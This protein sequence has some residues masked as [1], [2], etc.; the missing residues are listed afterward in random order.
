MASG[1]LRHDTDAMGSRRMQEGQVEP[2]LSRGGLRDGLR[3]AAPHLAQGCT[4]M[5]RV[6]QT[7]DVL[8]G[9]VDRLGEGQGQLLTESG[10]LREYRETPARGNPNRRA[11]Q[12]DPAAAAHTRQVC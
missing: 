9:P 10:D 6:P 12:I 7:D 2:E 5:H 8:G 1:H 11:G 4:L 3:G